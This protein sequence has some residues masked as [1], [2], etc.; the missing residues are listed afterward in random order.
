MAAHAR[1]LAH[2]TQPAHAPRDSAAHAPQRAQ[3]AAGDTLQTPVVQRTAQAPTAPPANAHAHSQEVYHPTRETRAAERAATHTENTMANVPTLPAHREMCREAIAH[4]LDGAEMHAQMRDFLPQEQVEHRALHRDMAMHSLKHADELHRCLRDMHGYAEPADGMVRALPAFLKTKDEGGDEGSEEMSREYKRVTAQVGK[5]PLTVSAIT[6]GMLGVKDARSARVELSALRDNAAELTTLRRQQGDADAR[7]ALQRC[8]DLIARHSAPGAQCVISPA[9]EKEMRGIDPATG[10]PSPMGRW[11]ENSIRDYVAKRM[12]GGPVA[13]ITRQG[14]LQPVS[15]SAGQPPSQA[16]W[17][18]PGAAQLAAPLL[19]GTQQTT[20]FP[21]VTHIRSA[22]VD[23]VSQE[24][25]AD[26]IPMAA[27]AYTAE[28]NSKSA[29]A[30]GVPVKVKDI[31][32]NEVTRQDANGV[33]VLTEEAV[34]SVVRAQQEGALQFSDLT[35]E[36]AKGFRM[37]PLNGR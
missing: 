3:G 20:N 31:Y 1:D 12:P 5:L 7:L 24:L 28:W 10:Q 22:P 15:A 18:H 33:A 2:Y 17:Q 37:S 13:D 8:D 14:A 16:P 35:A 25:R 34:L 26:Q 30:P 19:P 4:H 6:R 36:T 21:G 32:G 11:D 29:G 9:M 27:R 23:L